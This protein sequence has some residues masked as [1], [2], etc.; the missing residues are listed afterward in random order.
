MMVSSLSH[1]FSELMKYYKIREGEFFVRV[2]DL[3]H[4]IYGKKLIIIGN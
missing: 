2:I 3:D 4:L 1:Y